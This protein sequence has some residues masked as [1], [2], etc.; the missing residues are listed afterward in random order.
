M[1]VFLCVLYLIFYKIIQSVVLD[2]KG[3]EKKD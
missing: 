2:I 3:R 1:L